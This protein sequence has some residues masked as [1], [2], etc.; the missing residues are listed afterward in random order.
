[1]STMSLGSSNLESVEKKTIIENKLFWPAIL[2][3]IG[4]FIFF[5]WPSLILLSS[6]YLQFDI[7]SHGFFVPLVSAYATYQ[8]W[9]ES[10]KQ[11][12]RASWLGMPFLIVGISIMILGFWYYKALYLSSDRPSFIMSIGL[13]TCLCGLYIMWGGLSFLRVFAFPICFF[14]FAIPFPINFLRLVTIKLRLAVSIISE[15]VF[16]LLGFMVFR[17][18]NIL[19]LPNIS[20]GINDACSGIQSF[21]ILVA[22]A[23]VISYLKKMGFIETLFLCLLTVPISIFMNALRIVVTGFLVIHFGQEFATGWRHDL[24]GW[25]SFVGG[26]VSIIGLGSLFSQEKPI[27]EH[28]KIKSNLRT[29]ALSFS[30]PKKK[31]TLMLIM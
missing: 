1:M 15:D 22:G 12:F 18:G 7:Y 24:A 2:V 19:H 8:L 27:N 31:L 13:I 29:S 26:L 5:A 3:T 23:V 16:N 6:T 9:K 25:F 20:L 4:L 28:K 11:G 14:A 30:T 17:E 21:W 10:N